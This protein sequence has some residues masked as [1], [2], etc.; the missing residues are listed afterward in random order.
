MQSMIRHD[1]AMAQF[2]FRL[3]SEAEDFEAFQTNLSITTFPY[4]P[5]KAG[6]SETQLNAF[7]E[8]VMVTMQNSGEAFVTNAL[9]DGKFL[10]RACIVNF[11]TR[12]EDIA[13]LPGIIRKIGQN[14]L[15]EK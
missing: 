12:E 6:L 2:L 7:N 4:I 10:L 15:K 13:A 14:L 9:I 11:R 1:I 3:V 5:R 8:Q